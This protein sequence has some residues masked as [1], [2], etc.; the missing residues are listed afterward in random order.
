MDTARI[1]GVFLDEKF[2]NSIS[3]LSSLPIEASKLISSNYSKV[4]FVM[5]ILLGL[6]FIR[7]V[8]LLCNNVADS[9]T[10]S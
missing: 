9:L 7:V 1:R 5:I 8:N 2:W 6:F 4:K 10:M 3:M